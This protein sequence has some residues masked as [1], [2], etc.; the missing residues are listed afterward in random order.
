MSLI[1]Q[2]W[3]L[4]NSTNYQI[5]FSSLIC[6]RI[7]Q[8]EML[9]LFTLQS[10]LFI[11]L[12]FYFHFFRLYSPFPPSY[13]NVMSKYVHVLVAHQTIAYRKNIYSSSLHLFSH[14]IVNSFSKF[15]SK[16]F[17]REIGYV[18]CRGNV[19]RN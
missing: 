7:L 17:N 3:R 16:N 19:T 10:F 12:K 4:E 18:Q 5:L 13:E 9:R 8:S 2:N 6:F 14:F 11:D 1:C 15:K